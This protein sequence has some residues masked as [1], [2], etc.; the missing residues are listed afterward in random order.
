MV[1]KK[2]QQILLKKAKR[3]KQLLKYISRLNA[4][5]YRITNGK[6]SNKWAGQYP[7]MILT[8]RG[9]KTGK[10]RHIPLIKVLKD[11]QPI[12]VASLGGM[13]MNP[14]WFYS[15]C[16]NPKIEIQIGSNKKTYTA[17]RLPKTE[18]SSIWPIVCS[19]YPDY[20]VYQDRTTRDIPVF[21]CEGKQ[22]TQDW[23]DWIELN[24]TRGCDRNDMCNIL[25]NEG[26]DS[27]DIDM[28]MARAIEVSLWDSPPKLFLPNA[29]KID[30]D[31][32]NELYTLP[33]FLNPTECDRMAEIVRSKSYPST[34]VSEY[35][36]QVDENY[37][38]SSTC[39]IGRASCR[40]RV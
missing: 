14:D 9:K 13:P 6:L 38:T 26:F 15:V 30:S 10:K 7:I 21:L 29:Q 3:A 18:K 5:I 36:G 37:R 31:L 20:Q 2:K 23:K 32:V 39:E 4:F 12:L 24:R 11:N 25:L 28:E 35:G 33:N 22:I 19:H 40:E 8:V 27:K 17:R 1:D 16:A 34:V